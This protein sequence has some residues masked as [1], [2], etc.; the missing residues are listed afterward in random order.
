MKDLESL[1]I[2]MDSEVASVLYC[3]E[4]VDGA[5]AFLHLDSVVSVSA[6]ED[7]DEGFVHISRIMLPLL[8]KLL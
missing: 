7:E 2:S 5:G 6:S 1:G 8:R 4:V 3:D